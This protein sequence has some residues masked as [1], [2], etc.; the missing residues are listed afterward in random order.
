MLRSLPKREEGVE[1][2]RATEF[3]VTGYSKYV[4]FPNSTT[5]DRLFGDIPFKELPII[6]IRC[7]RN[8]THFLLTSHSG[9]PIYT[10]SCGVEGFKN[11]RKGTNVAAQVTATTFGKTLLKKGYKIA[12]VCIDGL[13]AGRASSFKG[14]ENAGVNIVSI[15]D[16]TK[17][18]E[19]PKQRPPGAKSL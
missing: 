5:P 11:C 9:L 2:E 4:E 10:R 17:I 13:G 19:Y 14:L 8:N 3:D 15:T 6:H 7:T 16:T 18:Y 12:R 1:G